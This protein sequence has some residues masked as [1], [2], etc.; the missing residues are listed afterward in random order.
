MNRD[1][2]PRY[3]TEIELDTLVKLKYPSGLIIHGLL[4][5]LLETPRLF[6]DLVEKFAARVERKNL[7]SEEEVHVM[8]SRLHRLWMILNIK[9]AFPIFKISRIENNK[10]ERIQKII[11]AEYKR[12]DSLIDKKEKKVRKRS[13]TPSPDRTAKRTPVL[14]KPKENL[15]LCDL[16]F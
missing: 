1:N 12:M 6:R 9:A 5:E 4:S 10:A 8:F 14:C 2:N 7:I 3:L 15:R 13:R 16:T 11:S